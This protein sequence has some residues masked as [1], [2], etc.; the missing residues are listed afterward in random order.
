QNNTVKII[1]QDDSNTLPDI[2]NGQNNRIIYRERIITQTAHINE[3]QSL[4]LVNDNVRVIR[5]DISSTNGNNSS[6]DEIE[7]SLSHISPSYDGHIITL[8]T[9]NDKRDIVLTNTGNIWIKE[10]AESVK[11]NYV[12]ESLSFIFNKKLNKWCQMY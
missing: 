9:S 2:N 4:M 11:L 10:N 6:D 7:V 5:L 8:Q 1:T 3:S 12:R